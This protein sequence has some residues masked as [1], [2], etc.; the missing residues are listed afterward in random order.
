[1]LFEPLEL[2]EKISVYP[3]LFRRASRIS[4]DFILASKQIIFR[5]IRDL[6][7]GNCKNQM[8]IRKCFSSKIRH[9]RRTT[10]IVINFGW[11]LGEYVERI[12]AVDEFRLATYIAEAQCLVRKWL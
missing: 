1:M 4:K 11:D 10:E 7:V 6:S 2:T 5:H 12:D 3:F 9:R 8:L